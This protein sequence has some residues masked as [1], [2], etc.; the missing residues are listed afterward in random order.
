MSSTGNTDMVVNEGMDGVSTTIR[1]AFHPSTFQAGEIDLFNN[2]TKVEK[3]YYGQGYKKVEI[4]KLRIK[5]QPLADRDGGNLLFYTFVSTKNVANIQLG[6]KRAVFK[7][8]KEIIGPQ[9]EIEL[10]NLMTNI[11]NDNARNV[12]E[13]NNPKLLVNKYIYNEVIRLNEFTISLATP[14]IVN[15]VVQYLYAQRD[16]NNPDRDFTR[17]VN[18]GISGHK[19]NSENFLYRRQ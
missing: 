15:Q 14:N 8:T 6:L 7:W 19:N 1:P 2:S 13:R 17:P 3:E 16:L 18:T 9:S 5:L 4:E 10:I 12:N 11:Y